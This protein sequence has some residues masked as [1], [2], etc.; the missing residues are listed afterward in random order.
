M[1]TENRR[2]LTQLRD[3]ARSIIDRGINPLTIRGKAAD[4]G[5]YG[6]DADPAAIGVIADALDRAVGGP[7]VVC[8]C[9]SSRFIGQMAVEAWELEKAGIIALSCHLLPSWYEGVQQDHQ[10]EHEGVAAQLD[11]LHLRKIDV[12]DRVRVVN[13]TGYIGER[14]RAEIDYAESIGCPVQFVEMPGC[15]HKGTLLPRGERWECQHCHELFEFA[16]PALTPCAES[17]MA[18]ETSA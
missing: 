14:T 18:S 7:E 17:E 4:G 3:A 11:E 1:H 16:T 2:V 5:N 8:L 13:I 9:G 6:L 10:A 15:E 12:S